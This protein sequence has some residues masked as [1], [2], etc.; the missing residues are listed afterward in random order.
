MKKRL[1]EDRNTEINTYH[2][3]HKDFMADIGLCGNNT[4]LR[5]EITAAYI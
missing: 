2:V 1:S 5:N 4:G 3:L